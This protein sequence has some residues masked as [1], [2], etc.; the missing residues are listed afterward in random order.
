MMNDVFIQF[1]QFQLLRGE[2]VNL[3]SETEEELFFVLFSS[4]SFWGGKRAGGKT[5]RLIQL[6]QNEKVSGM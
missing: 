4:E 3:D 5:S 6:G 2:P 1:P